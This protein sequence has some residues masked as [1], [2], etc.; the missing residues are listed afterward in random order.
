MADQQDESGM[1][2]APEAPQGRRPRRKRMRRVPGIS[3]NPATNLL[4]ADVVLSGLTRLVRRNIEKSMLR[5]EY[6]PEE[7]KRILNG[8]SLGQ[9]VTNHTA[10]RIAT[11]SL[12]GAVLITGGLLAKAMFDRSASKRR[13]AK[14][15]RKQLEEQA[16]RAES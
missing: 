5:A 12:P 9:T 2:Q 14:A 4:I 8:R 7:A 15:G 3:T 6:D 13:A 1:A 10:S 11:R 16:D